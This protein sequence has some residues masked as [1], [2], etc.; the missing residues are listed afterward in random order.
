V[1]TSSTQLIGHRADF[2]AGQFFDI[3]LEVHQPKNGSEAIGLPL[4]EK[5]TFTITKDG[6]TAPV[7][8]Y[9]KIQEPKLEKWNFTWYEGKILS[10]LT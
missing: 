1:H 9:F 7:T 5:F 4:D 2:L 3:R 10:H 6:K 8:E